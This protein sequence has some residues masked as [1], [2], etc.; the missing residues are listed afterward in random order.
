M[1]A[2]TFSILL[3]SATKDPKSVAT[4]INA[5]VTSKEDFKT[6]RKEILPSSLEHLEIVVNAQDLALYDPMELAGWATCLQEGATVSVK[7]SG[8]AST[9]DVKPITTSFLLAGMK[10]AGEKRE[11]DGSRVF[12]ATRTANNSAMN[13]SKAI[14]LPKK[15][16]AAAVSISLDDDDDLIDEDN[17]LSDDKLAPPPAMSAD[18]KAGDDCS[19][20]KACDDCTCGRADAEAAAEKPKEVK[21]SSCGKCGL[22]DAFRCASCPYLGLPAFKPGEEHLVL[23][24]NDDL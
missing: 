13:G 9:A 2:K 17:L 20:R 14:P 15:K 16:S 12:T 6:A 3:G 23:Q 21:K 5:T 1:A 8:D 4:E 22:G 19:G 24:L 18:K 7:V 10:G 11:A